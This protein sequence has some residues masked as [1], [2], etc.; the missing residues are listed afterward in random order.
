K[1]LKPTPGLE[2][3]HDRGASCKTLDSRQPFLAKG[4]RPETLLIGILRPK[5]LKNPR[6]DRAGSVKDIDGREFDYI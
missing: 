1:T 6:R 2:E 5:C 4:L 3:S